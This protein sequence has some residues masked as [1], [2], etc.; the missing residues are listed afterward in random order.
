M[1][2]ETYC[3]L[4]VNFNWQ[5]TVGL[6]Y[7]DTNCVIFYKIVKYVDFFVYLLQKQY[8]TKTSIEY[9]LYMIST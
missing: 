9:I 6:M 3:F 2:E 5:V 8:T 7:S 1:F 4:F